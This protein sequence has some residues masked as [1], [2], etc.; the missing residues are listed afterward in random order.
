LLQWQPPSFLNH[1]G[2]R[3]QVRLRSDSWACF[4]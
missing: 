1:R 4:N 3:N 2:E